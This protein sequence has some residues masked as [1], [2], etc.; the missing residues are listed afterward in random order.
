MYPSVP[1]FRIARIYTCTVSILFFLICVSCR[2]CIVCVCVSLMLR[3]VIDCIVN[4]SYKLNKGRVVRKKCGFWGRRSDGRRCLCCLGFTEVVACDLDHHRCW[5]ATAEDR[6]SGNIR[7]CRTSG[8]PGWD[9]AM[10]FP[11]LLRCLLLWTL[12]RTSS[13][14]THRV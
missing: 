11:V 2:V 3:T 6:R 8:I 1:K 4:C 5:G 13:V 14:C 7:R 10:G 9:L 12:P